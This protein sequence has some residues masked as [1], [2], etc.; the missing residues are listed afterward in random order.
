[1]NESLRKALDRPLG[2]SALEQT[3]FPGDRILFVPDAEFASDFETLSEIV[4]V[5]LEHGIRAEDLSVLLTE[6][7]ERSATRELRPRLRPEIGL[8]FHRPSQRDRLAL[9]GVDAADEPITLCRDLIDADMVVSIG[10]YATKRTG[11]YFGPH[12]AIF[13]RFA[14]GE[15][16]IRF[17]QTKG[18]ARRKLKEEVREV[19]KQLGIV[20]TIQFF[21]PRGF[22]TQVAAGSPERIEESW[23]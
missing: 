22:P 19:A 16:Q 1:M 9:L 4:D 3:F 5:F 7:E 14:D 23:E 21:T 17:S 10:R 12:T 2:F 11:D 18:P 13:P 8:L 20:F 6:T 15:T